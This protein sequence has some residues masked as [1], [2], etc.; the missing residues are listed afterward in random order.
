MR[1][2]A[3]L[4]AAFITLMGALILSPAEAADTPPDFAITNGHFYSQTA[5]GGKGG[6]SITDDGGVPMWTEF[7][8]LGG[9][10]VLGYPVS[11]RFM[12]QDH[13]VQLMQKVGLVW[14]PETGHMQYLDIFDILHKAGR[15]GWLLSAKGIPPAVG[16]ADEAGKSWEQVSQQRYKMLDLHPA[17]KD[18]YF[19]AADPVNSYGLPTSN[20]LEAPTASMMRFDNVVIQQWK[21]LLPWAAAGQVNLANGGDILKESGLLGPAPFALQATPEIPIVPAAPPVL[22]SS[23]VNQ[24]VPSGFAVASFYADYFEGRHTSSGQV[25]TQDALTC[26]TNAYPLGTRLRLTT[27]DGARSVE[28]INNDR[29]AAWNTRIDLSKAAFAE[30]YPLG[31]GIGTVKVEV[32]A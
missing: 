8:R 22:P 28:V 4:V 31:S 10:N 1:K 18:V 25:F 6:Y 27:P 32:L 17:I 21:Q 11:G 5:A 9:V 20:W 2:G 16:F 24:S 12:Y 13:I 7:Q 23:Q 3:T 14:H 19:S 29:P 26:A 15:D 30:L